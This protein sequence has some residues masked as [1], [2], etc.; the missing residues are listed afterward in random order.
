[1]AQRQNKCFVV[2]WFCGRL[3]QV[4]E[5]SIIGVLHVDL[6]A[7]PVHI[8]PCFNDASPEFTDLDWYRAVDYQVKM[9]LAVCTRFA[10]REA[11]NPLAFPSLVRFVKARI[12]A[13]QEVGNRCYE[14]FVA[15]PLAVVVD[16]LGG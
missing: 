4:L 11:R 6:F 3:R 9:P 12:Q 13:I 1:M 7:S 2:V 16:L 5:P 10:D 14:C 8:S 15:Q